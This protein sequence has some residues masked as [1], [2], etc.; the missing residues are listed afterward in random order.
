MH[1]QRWGLAAVEVVFALEEDATTHGWALDSGRPGTDGEEHAS[2]SARFIEYHEE[3]R[4]GPPQGEFFDMYKWVVPHVNGI[5]H[6]ALMP[7]ETSDE[8]LQILRDSFISATQD[9]EFRQEEVKMF[10][11]NLPVVDSDQGARILHNLA[12]P[13]GDVKSFLMDYVQQ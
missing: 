13:P 8:A 10:G 6:L 4:G 2:E 12:N 11:V 1:D 3:M 9:E 5:V 7:L